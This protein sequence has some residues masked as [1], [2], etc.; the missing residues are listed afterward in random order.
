MGH[1]AAPVWSSTTYP[2]TQCRCVI[3]DISHLVL[4]SCPALCCPVP[5]LFDY[6]SAL[7]CNSGASTQPAPAPSNTAP[8]PTPACAGE[9]GSIPQAPRLP[10]ACP[11]HTST[12]APGAQQAGPGCWAN[13]A[14]E[15]PVLSCDWHQ[16]TA[17]PRAPT[18]RSDLGQHPAS[19]TPVRLSYWRLHQVFMLI[20]S[21]QAG[22]PAACPSV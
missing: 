17:Q 1:A 11:L 2:S 4:A 20:Q 3:T 9:G 22:P 15:F 10:R 6:S 12:A 19:R 14:R 8:P 18:Q 21:L 5:R 13:A 16:A 7:C